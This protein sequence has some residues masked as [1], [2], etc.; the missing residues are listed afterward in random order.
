MH[1]RKWHFFYARV[2]K[3]Y[4]EANTTR[5]PKIIRHSVQV[6]WAI[7]VASVESM[8]MFFSEL[9]PALG[10]SIYRP[11]VFYTVILFVLCGVISPFR[12]MHVLWGAATLSKI[13]SQLDNST[14][15]AHSAAVAMPLVAL[16]AGADEIISHRGDPLI[17]SDVPQTCCHCH[18]LISVIVVVIIIFY[19]FIN[20]SITAGNQ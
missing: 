14:E 10:C 13:L 6:S 1:K 8:K 17:G 18:R 19:S 4:S 9:R 12:L 20:L 2:A 5:L 7:Q 16:F 3:K 11:Y 15:C